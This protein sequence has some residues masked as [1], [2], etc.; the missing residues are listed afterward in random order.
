MTAQLDQVTDIIGNVVQVPGLGPDD[1]LNN[2]VMTS[3]L[4]AAAAAKLNETFAVELSLDAVASAQTPR[5][6]HQLIQGLSK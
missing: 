2:G 3:I 1:R 5:E 6:V 4:A